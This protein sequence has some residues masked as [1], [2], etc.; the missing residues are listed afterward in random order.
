MLISFSIKNNHWIER[1]CLYGDNRKKCFAFLT[2]II[3]KLAQ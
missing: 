3:L 1:D 2:C